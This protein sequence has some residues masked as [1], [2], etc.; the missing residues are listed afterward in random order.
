MRQMQ[1]L[2]AQRAT[3]MSHQVTP[4]FLPFANLDHIRAPEQCCD[5]GRAPDWSIVHRVWGIP[6]PYFP[7]TRG[8]RQTDELVGCTE[9]AAVTINGSSP[10]AAPA[11]AT[12]SA[13]A[14]APANG[15]ATDA[16]GSAAADAAKRVRNLQKKLRQVRCWA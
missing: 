3:P 2:R 9:L 1:E 7:M 11:D 16:G 12:A 10:A 5:L 6:I 15:S 8:V 4:Q 13:P 14:A